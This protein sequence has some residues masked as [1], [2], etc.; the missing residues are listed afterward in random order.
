VR[1]HAR[2]AE[3]RGITST[4]GRYEQTWTTPYGQ[5]SCTQWHENMN[6]HERFVAAGDMLTGAWDN[7]LD[8][9]R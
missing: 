1:S 3:Y 6:A 8:P 9:E 4:I 2:G 5:T 7:G